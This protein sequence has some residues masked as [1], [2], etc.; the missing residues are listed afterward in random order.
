MTAKVP[1]LLAHRV[2]TTRYYYYY[3]ADSIRWYAAPADYK[4]KYKP[5]CATSVLP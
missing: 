5:V 2:N 4:S 3:Y 1:R